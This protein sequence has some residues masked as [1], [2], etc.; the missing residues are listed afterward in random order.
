MMYKGKEIRHTEFIGL[1]KAIGVNGGRRKTYY[2]KLVEMAG[3]GNIKAV[4]LLKDLEV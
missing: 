2:Q 1:C 3:N 4:E